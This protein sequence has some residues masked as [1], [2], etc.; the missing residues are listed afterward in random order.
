MKPIVWLANMCLTKWIREQDG[1]LEIEH[2]LKKGFWKQLVGLTLS[3]LYTHTCL[4]VMDI[5]Q[6]WGYNHW[7]AVSF[8]EV[9][10]DGSK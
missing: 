6:D 5:S 2:A 9:L 8:P 3:V 10:Q 7:K 4:S 1:P